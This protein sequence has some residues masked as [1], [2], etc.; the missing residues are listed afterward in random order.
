MEDALVVPFEGALQLLFHLQQRR[1]R[2]AL[3]RHADLPY[4]SADAQFMTQSL[5]S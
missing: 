4:Q 2:L 3:A 5:N 1:A